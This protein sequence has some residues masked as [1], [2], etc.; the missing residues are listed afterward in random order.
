MPNQIN[1]STPPP[2]P[3]RIDPVVNRELGDNNAYRGIESHGVPRTNEWT[4]VPSALDENE[5]VEAFDVSHAAID[6]IPVKI[7]N[8]GMREL[9]SWQVRHEYATNAA[10]RILPLNKHSTK[11]RV[12]NIGAATVWVAPDVSVAVFTG[13]PIPIN[14]EWVFEGQTE[15]WAISEDGAQQHLVIMSEV[16]I[17]ER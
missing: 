3:E 10:N 4:Q 15:V 7:V 9:R 8:E 5:E 11:T 16:T 6:P 1:T 17:T 2:D 14:T 13:Y 12:R